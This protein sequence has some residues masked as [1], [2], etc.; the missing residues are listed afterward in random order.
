MLQL[1]QSSMYGSKSPSL[2][3]LRTGRAGII[4]IDEILQN[5]KKDLAYFKK[6][7]SRGTINNHFLD[8]IKLIHQAR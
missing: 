8:N 3:S 2:A 4:D 5:E 1:P 6:V 7:E